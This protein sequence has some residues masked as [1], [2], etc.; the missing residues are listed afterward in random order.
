MRDALKAD[1]RLVLLEYRKEDPSIPIR[2]EHKMSVQEVKLEVEA[3]GFHM[4]K[5]LETLPRQHIIILTK[6]KPN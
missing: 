3:E 2:P 6:T 5:V 1:G 4:D